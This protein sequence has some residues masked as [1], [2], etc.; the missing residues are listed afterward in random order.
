L[1]FQYLT[2]WDLFLTPLF[3]FVLAA[4]AKRVRDRKYPVSHPMHKYFMPGLYLKLGGAIFI[5][6]LYA[7]Y[8]VGG[9]TYNYFNQARTIN[10]ADMES[11]FKLML[12]TSFDKDPKLY[13][14]ISQME[15]YNDPSSFMV[16]RITAIFG[17]LT[18]TNYMPTALLFAYFSFYGIWAMYRAFVNIFPYLVK[19]FAVAFLFIPSVI[20]WGSSIFK[21]TVCMFAL[22]WLTYTTF[23]VFIHRDFSLKNIFMLA[24]GFILIANVK[25]YI[26][27]GFVP[28]LCA[29]I[30][31]TYSRK[32][33]S[34]GLRWLVNLG[35]I[36]LIITSFLFF[37]QKFA[38]ELNRYSLASLAKTATTTREW[39]SY[40]SEVDQG[41]AYDLGNF[42]P[43]LKGML[44][45]FPQAVVVTLFRPF[46]WEAR[47]VIVFLSALEALAFIYFT[48]KALKKKGNIRLIIKNPTVLFC[49]IFSLI[50]AFAVGISSYNF[51]ALSRYKIPCLPFYASFLIIL[52]YHRK[53]EE[54]S[55]QENS[56]MK[57]PELAETL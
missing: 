27:I 24:F 28:A 17:L 1:I 21:D 35:F 45:K 36:A 50:F 54:E 5:G 12:H 18:G 11:W 52:L 26:L 2:V 34:T 49:L 8:Y 10:S 30:S 46:P 40:M 47:K 6:F 37:S 29:W 38:T 4:I 19:E 41:S 55:I 48:F 22:G 25:I 9:D 33:H 44:T 39:I 7:Y 14:Y 53:K 23:R 3:F 51:G 32:I 57:L 15:W 43:T 42:D 56:E 13:P 31:L 16:V 20:I